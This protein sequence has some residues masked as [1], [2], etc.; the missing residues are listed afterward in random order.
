MRADDCSS[1]GLAGASRDYEAVTSYLW[2]ALGGMVGANTRYLVSLWAAR[3]F[4]IRFPYGTFII[5]ISGSLGLGV[6]STV[7]ARNLDNSLTLSLL[8]ATGFFG[9]YTTFSTFSYESLALIQDDR[10]RMA[11]RNIVGS[12]ALGVIGALLGISLTLAVG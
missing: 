3:R 6:I 10:W 11:M 2:V 7:I 5:N 4:G 8:I 12:A 1:A 9:A